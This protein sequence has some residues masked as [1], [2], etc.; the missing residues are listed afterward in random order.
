[1]VW[2]CRRMLSKEASG[3]I[4]VA[5]ERIY[6]KITGAFAFGKIIPLSGQR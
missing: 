4:K 1:M 5:G 2:M 6:L 3:R